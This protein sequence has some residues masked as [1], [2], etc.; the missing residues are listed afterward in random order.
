[1]WK[2]LYYEKI[3][4]GTEELDKYV[5][6]RT[7]AENN[8]KQH[9][10]LISEA[11]QSACYGTFRNT[12]TR[13]KNNNKKTVLWWTDNLTIM[14]RRVNAYRRLFQR[15]KNDE[16]LREDRKKNYG[17]SKRTYQTEIK[18]EK[19]NSWKNTAT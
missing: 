19:L 16:K 14:R 17:E 11:I 4:G 2:A 18:K 1:M 9:I 3:E 6:T 8:L 5:S 7:A 10:E 15:T 13:E 12:T